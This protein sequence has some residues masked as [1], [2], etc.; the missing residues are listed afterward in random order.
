MDATNFKLNLTLSPALITF[1]NNKTQ[2]PPIPDSI[3]YTKLDG[4]YFEPFLD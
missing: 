4:L 1:Q 3:R 2:V